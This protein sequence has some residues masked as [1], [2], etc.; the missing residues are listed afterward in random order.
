VPQIPE[1]IGGWIIEHA[2]RTR[3]DSTRNVPSEAA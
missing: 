1:L 3:A 2:A